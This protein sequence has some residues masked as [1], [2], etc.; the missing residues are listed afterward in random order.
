MH[1]CARLLSKM[2]RAP[3]S[4]LFARAPL[5][6]LRPSM[7]GRPCEVSYD[8]A[9]QAIERVAAHHVSA[10]RSRNGADAEAGDEA[11]DDANEWVDDLKSVIEPEWWPHWPRRERGAFLA[12][13]D[14]LRARVNDAALVRS[15]PRLAHLLL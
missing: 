1:S 13:M 11:H 9:V 8:D 2:A 12:D 6:I 3:S 14:R 15:F 5:S 4:P 10:V 7:T